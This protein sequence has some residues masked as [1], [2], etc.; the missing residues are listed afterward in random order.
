MFTTEFALSLEAAGAIALS[1]PAIVLTTLV[2]TRILGLRTFS[3]MSAFDFSITVATGSLIATVALQGSSLLAGVVGLA[4]LMATQ[5]SIAL[6]RLTGAQRGIDNQPLLLM[7]H[8][9]YLDDNL[10]AARVTRGDVR[11]KLREANALRYEDVVAVVLE[12]TGDVSVLHGDG[13]I[14]ADLMQD[15]RR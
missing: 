5:W 3:K 8:G 11:A 10:R 2:Y 7:S 4:A 9:E 12:T 15:V 1:G 6:L 14:D 13:P